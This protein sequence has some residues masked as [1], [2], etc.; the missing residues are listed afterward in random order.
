MEVQP[1]WAI[2]Y[3]I[4][5]CTEHDIGY[6]LL[7]LYREDIAMSMVQIRSSTFIQLLVGI[8]EEERWMS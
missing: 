5:Q 3:V 1:K 7:G 8:L 2:A 4:G 6:L